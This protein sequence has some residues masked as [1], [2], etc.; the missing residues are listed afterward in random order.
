M[1]IKDFNAKVRIG[2][3]VYVGNRPLKWRT[4]TAART[5][6]SYASSAGFAAPSSGFGRETPPTCSTNAAT[7]TDTCWPSSP[8]AKSWS[9]PPSEKQANRWES[10]SRASVRSARTAE[11][12]STASAS[13]GS[14]L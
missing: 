7:K 10:A 12:R 4:S 8:A 13:S 14:T 9:S 5:K 2:S 1:K 6:P 11:R 3:T